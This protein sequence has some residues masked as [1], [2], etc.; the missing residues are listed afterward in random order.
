MFFVDPEKKKHEVK[1]KQNR[2]K[3]LVCFVYVRIG[4]PTI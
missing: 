3:V 1:E 2:E 4:Y